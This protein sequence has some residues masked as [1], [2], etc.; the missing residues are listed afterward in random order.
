LEELTE[1]FAA[2][3]ATIAFDAIGGG[4]LPGQLLTCME[5]ALIAR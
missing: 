2:T 4:K 5:A 1:A 3:G